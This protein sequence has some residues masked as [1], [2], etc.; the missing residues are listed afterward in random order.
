MRISREKSILLALLFVIHSAQATSL[1]S[2]DSYRPIAAD[3]TARNV[4]QSLTVLI[5][6]QATAETSANTDTS[7][8]TDISGDVRGNDNR[9]TGTLN[10]GNDYEG[11]GTLSRSGRLV[12]SVTVTILE[13][14]E[15][16][17]LLIGGE[18]LIEFNEENQHI[19]VSG[20]VRPDDIGANN[21]VLSTRVADAKITYV[22]DGLLGERQSP[23][24]ISRF[25]NWLW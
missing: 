24:I 10:L 4:G 23:G 16:G 7:S 13:K 11:G 12:A 14:L 9:N 5:Y 20:R 18:Q 3:Y 1:Y 8:L 21:T 2:D 17:E 22:G 15:S 25:F 6:E 19:R